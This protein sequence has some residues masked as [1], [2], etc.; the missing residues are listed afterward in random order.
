MADFSDSFG[1]VLVL[2]DQ[3]EDD[4]DAK[5]VSG[6]DEPRSGPPGRHGF[7]RRLRINETVD[8]GLCAKRTDG[9]A[10]AVGHDH[11]K[12]LRRGTNGGVGLVVD[13]ERTRDVEE[14]ERHTVDDHREDEHP[15]AAAGIAEPEQPEAQHPCEHG[16]QHDVL[17]AETLE[18]ER[19]Q[20]YA[21]RLG[22]LR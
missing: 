7:D 20:E 3:G 16:H 13:E 12:S 1:I 4:G 2:E 6:E 21:E 18:T 14:V 5:G 8:D 19:N 9:G 17:D 22:D 15:Y 11:E 10:D